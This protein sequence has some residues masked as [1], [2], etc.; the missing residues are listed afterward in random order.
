MARTRSPATWNSRGFSRHLPGGNYW[1]LLYKYPARALRHHAARYLRDWTLPQLPLPCY[2]VTVDLVSGQSVVRDQGDAVRAILE[3][4]N[5]PG[6]SL[7]IC[8]DGQAA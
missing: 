8:R 6:L 1:Y 7:P 3:S 5:L 4:I 2:A